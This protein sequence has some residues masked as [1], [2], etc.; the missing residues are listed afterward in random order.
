MESRPSAT[1]SAK[2][3]CD[4]GPRAGRA[5]AGLVVS[6]IGALVVSPA[7]ATLLAGQIGST[8][9]RGARRLG[10]WL[11]LV[12][13]PPPS[14]LRVSDS[15]SIQVAE[16]A[17]VVLMGWPAGATTDDKLEYLRRQTEN[18]QQQLSL[19]RKEARDETARVEQTLAQARG[20]LERGHGALLVR[21]EQSERL[22]TEVDSRALPVVAAG[23]LLS[24]LSPE[25]GKH[26]LVAWP[27]LAASLAS[28]SGSPSWLDRGGPRRWA[29]RTRPNNYKPVRCLARHGEGRYL[30]NRRA[31]SRSATWARS[32]VPASR[33]RAVAPASTAT[34]HRTWT[35]LIMYLSSKVSW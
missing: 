6:L 26:P 7:G 2:T 17:T 3:E 25:L 24:G 14:V 18:L 8:L 28:L 21:V 30:I 23:I 32:A 19:A 9:A 13:V 34:A 5:L 29:P 10:A 12:A 16:S 20:D 1:A 22:A 11:G 33:P 35:L 15:D 31:R 27:V 4:G